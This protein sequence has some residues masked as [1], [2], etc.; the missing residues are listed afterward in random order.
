MIRAS[1]ETITIDDLKHY[2]AVIQL[3]TRSYDVA[4]LDEALPRWYSKSTG[5]S[6]STELRQPLTEIQRVPLIVGDDELPRSPR[7]F[8]HVAYKANATFF[9]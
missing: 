7:G 9:Q 8:V 5:V 4:A 2:D 6:P 1:A 3:A